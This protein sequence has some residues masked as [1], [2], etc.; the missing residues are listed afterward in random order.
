MSD[1]FGSNLLSQYDV[2]TLPVNASVEESVH[3]FQQHYQSQSG[4]SLSSIHF[5]IAYL[6][7]SKGIYNSQASSSSAHTAASTL[8]R[9]HHGPPPVPYMSRPQRTA[10]QAP[11]TSRAHEKDAYKEAKKGFRP[12][13]PPPKTATGKRCHE[14]ISVRS[15]AS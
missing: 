1:N 14:K 15:Y 11:S 6:T 12:T 13:I 5:L 4:E 7:R 3:I 8:P 9:P 2:P 10:S